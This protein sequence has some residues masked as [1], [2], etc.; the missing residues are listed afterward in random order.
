MISRKTFIIV[1]VVILIIVNIIGLSRIGKT[2]NSSSGFQRFA[3][4]GISPVQSVV[5]KSIRSFKSVWSNYFLLISVSRENEI[6]RKK[7]GVVTKEKN[8][9]IEVAYENERLKKLLSFKQN[10]YFSTK[11]AKVIGRDMSKW[12]KTVIIDQGSAQGIRSGLSVVVSEGV[13][14]Q[15]TEVALNHSKVLLIEDRNSAVDALIQRNRARGVIKGESTDRCFLDYALLKNDIRVGDIIISSG[16]DGLYPKGLRIGKVTKVVRPNA[17]I[18]QDVIV[19][20]FVDFEK[21]EEVLVIQTTKTKSK[22]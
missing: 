6:L 15:V 5:S 11:A 12:F 17:G 19:T 20:P 21:L 13:V 8:K 2:K 1:G 7:L 3:L 14:G 10:H 22:M 18:F 4:Y 16:L 9:Y